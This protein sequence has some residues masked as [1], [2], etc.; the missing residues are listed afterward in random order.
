M[1]YKILNN[2]NNNK[3]N[4]ILTTM[5]KNLQNQHKIKTIIFLVIIKMEMRKM[6]K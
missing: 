4:F 6:T 1:T 3:V 2:N 5:R